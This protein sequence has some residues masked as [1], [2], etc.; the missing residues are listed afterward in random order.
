MSEWAMNIVRQVMTPVAV[1]ELFLSQVKRQIDES[2]AAGQPMMPLWADRVGFKVGPRGGVTIINSPLTK[3]KP[4]S[5]AAQARKRLKMIRQLRA[6]HGSP[7]KA[8]L[9]LAMALAKQASA[10]SKAWNQSGTLA[11]PA[12]KPQKPRRTKSGLKPG[13][14][15]YSYRRG[16]RPLIDTRAGYG[17]ISTSASMSWPSVSIKVTAPAYM[18]GQHSGFT[19]K[20]PNFIPLTRKAKTSHTTGIDPRLEGLKRG[21]DYWMVWKGVTIPPR[22]FA[23]LGPKFM[24]RL[25]RSLFRA[26]KVANNG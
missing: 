25:A 15:H 4:S 5:G 24:H 8:A 14:I 26:M 22:P 13:A 7:R 23:K 11:L 21:K 19:T 12:P 20:G 10:S 3:S 18:V 6:V 1:E 9:K 2:E 17:A 16:G